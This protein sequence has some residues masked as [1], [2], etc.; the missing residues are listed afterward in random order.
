MLTDL[1]TPA[2]RY[3]ALLNS[4]L[5]R[6]MPEAGRMVDWVRH[7]VGVYEQVGFD[8][9]PWLVQWPHEKDIRAAG[10]TD[11]RLEELRRQ[12][13]RSDYGSA[14]DVAQVLARYPD[15][16]TSDRPFLITFQTLTRENSP[17]WRWHKNGEY[18][19]S[20]D[21]Q[22]EHLGDEPNIEQIITWSI[23]QVTAGEV[24]LGRHWNEDLATW[25]RAR[26]AGQVVPPIMLG[27]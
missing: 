12:E 20:Q 1:P 21:P 5:H 11:A 15:L 6:R 17:G 25:L 22:C 3:A 8:C 2:V 26:M 13:Y 23:W 18:I 16:A 7:G 14:D 19:G 9:L 27:G 24:E 4:A 10:D